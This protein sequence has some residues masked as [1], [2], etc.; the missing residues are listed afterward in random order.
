MLTVTGQPGF[1]GT[2]NFS[3]ASCAGLPR[4]S[5]CS[6]NPASVT[7]SGS[8]T[9]T[10]STTAAHSA[11]LE[12]P[13]GWTTSL[14]ATLAGIFLLGKRPRRRN[15]SRLLSLSAVAC[16][17]TIVSCGGGSGGGG[18]NND[19]GTPPGTSTVTVTATS[20]TLTHTAT[21]TLTIQ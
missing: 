13:A 6:F 17:I 10:V 20:G 21:L 15:W 4:E 8:T 2:I 9:L 12:G 19:P 1:S 14:A 18:R 7:N 16:L 3:A 11:S 5:T